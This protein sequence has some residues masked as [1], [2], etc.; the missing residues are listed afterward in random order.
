MELFDNLVGTQ[1]LIPHGHCYLWQTELVGL[2]AGSDGLTA[3]AYYAIAL[4]LVYFASQR[5]DIPFPW[6]F[7]LFGAFIASCGTTHL[8]DTVTL[9]Y[10]IYWVSGAIKA[11]TAI[12]SIYTAIALVP[13]MPQALAFP[14]P[15]QLQQINRRLH[16]EIEERQHAETK[17]RNFNARLEQQVA[18]RTEDLR[19]A[20]Q[21]LQ[22]R[23]QQRRSLAELGQYALRGQD[24]SALMEHAVKIVARAID[25]EYCKILELLPDG[26]AFV[27]R[28]G[29]GWNPGLVGR[30]RV[31]GDRN[32][33]AGYTLLSKRPVIVENLATESRFSGN[34]ILHDHNVAAGVSVVIPGKE[35]PFGVLGIHTR[36]HR[37]FSHDDIYFL[38][39]I[40]N[41]L[42]TAIDRKHMEQLLFEEKELAQVTLQSIGDAVITTDATGNVRS[43]NPIAEQLTGW[44]SEDARGRPLDNV[45]CIVSEINRRPLD[46]PL[47]PVFDRGEIVGL[48][49]HTLLVARDGTEYAIEDSAAP[50]RMENGYLLGAVLVFRDVTHSR[51]LAHRLSW[52]SSHDELT[53]LANRRAFERYLEDGAIAAMREEEEHTLCYVDLDRFKVV[54]DTCG[55]VAG[56]ELLRQV[57]QLFQFHCRKSDIL[58]RVGG[59]EFGLL[60]Y[61][62]SLDRGRQIARS[63]I[64]AF[65]NFHFVWGN[66]SFSIGISIG[67][68][69][70]APNS[71]RQSDFFSTNNLLDAAEAA[72]YA[73]KYR[74]R[75]RLHVYHPDDREVTRHLSESHWVNRLNRA[76]Q[77]D[78]FVLYYQPIAPLKSTVAVTEHYEVLLRLIGDAG[79]VISPAAFM[80]AAERYNLMPKVDRWVIQTFFKLKH[81]ALERGESEAIANSVYAI[82]LSGA[83]VNDEEFIEFLQQQFDRYQIPPQSICFEIT[84]TIALNSLSKA[85][86]FIRDL[87]SLGCQFALDDFGSGTSSFSYLKHLPVDYLKIDGH[88]VRDILKDPIDLEIVKAIDAIGHVMNLKTIAEFVSDEKI[89]TKVRELGVDYA[90]GF[91]IAKPQPLVENRLRL[92]GD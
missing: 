15:A 34:R 55:H 30:A 42:S 84:E 76:C 12:I 62:C 37:T 17:V 70:I 92:T 32:S 8:M 11:I 23:A 54:N 90:Q 52:Q 7:W 78:R 56:D 71:I 63:L 14:S 49:N 16:R 6:V 39:A 73:A 27:L 43:L 2:H 87:R 86:Q 85:A 21:T 80:P 91:G 28:W 47:A 77:D 81:D 40:A 24:L 50:I 67:L 64:D 33:Q 66:S 79:E 59:D 75:N 13:I 18:Q 45:F 1:P 46:N 31:S 26:D 19:L 65:A 68:V 60:L 36:E 82:N 20:N 74:G 48:A 3:I 38:Q 41:I 35:R 4:T 5:Q 58:A 89:L 83:S 44:T 51:T 29:I 88:F 72:C 22:T 61:R 69:A 10:P 57:G 53:E 25:V 9:W